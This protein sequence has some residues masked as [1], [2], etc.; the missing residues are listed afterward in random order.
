MHASKT[1]KST[2]N[3]ALGY[4]MIML[5]GMALEPAERET[6]THVAS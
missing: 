6:I 4:N 3:L 1:M 2:K 5:M